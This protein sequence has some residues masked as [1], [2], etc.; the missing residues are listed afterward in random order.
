MV[1]RIFRY[2]FPILLVTVLACEGGGGE[3][4]SNERS[5]S[6]VITWCSGD[7]NA[8]LVGLDRTCVRL[9][10]NDSKYARVT[11]TVNGTDHELPGVVDVQTPAKD[12]VVI[13]QLVPASFWRKIVL[14]PTLTGTDGTQLGLDLTADS[15]GYDDLGGV[16]RFSG[17]MTITAMGGKA[18]STAAHTARL[19]G[20]HFSSAASIQQ[21]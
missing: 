12:H 5:A 13:K 15:G 10:K 21:L 11:M 20:L 6:R 8:R 17:S 19:D 4:S 18:S 3:S 14:P 9:A 7:L 2:S 1:A 16:S